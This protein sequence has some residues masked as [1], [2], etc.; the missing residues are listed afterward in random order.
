MLPSHRRQH[1]FY[2]SA[3]PHPV[4]ADVAGDGDNPPDA[5][6]DAGAG[7]ETSAAVMP[8]ADGPDEGQRGSNTTP[9]ERLIRDSDE[10]AAAVR[11]LEGLLPPPTASSAEWTHMRRRSNIQID[12]TEAAYYLDKAIKAE[13]A[14]AKQQ[15]LNKAQI[16][17]DALE[18]F[19][20]NLATKGSLSA[21]E[22]EQF[23]LTQDKL[24]PLRRLKRKAEA[25]ISLSGEH[26]Q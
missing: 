20:Q 9:T 13:S 15:M 11:V 21:D 22:R 24:P 6:A 23:C 8:S 3:P 25:T 5:D 2:T 16:R 4:V 17:L 26:L 10:A 19:A 12:A 14:R 7:V 1:Y 18:K